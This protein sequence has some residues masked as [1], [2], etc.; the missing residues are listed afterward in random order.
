MSPGVIGLAG[1]VDV[2]TLWVTVLIVIGLM[3]VAKLPREKAV[4]AGL[5]VWVLGGLPA[6]WQLARSALFG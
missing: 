3:V 2:F 6:I 4:P 1:R 5:V